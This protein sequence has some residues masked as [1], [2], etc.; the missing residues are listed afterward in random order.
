MEIICLITQN[1]EM[2]KQIEVNT[3]RRAD[4]VGTNSI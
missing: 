2:C 4:R 3:G 1:D